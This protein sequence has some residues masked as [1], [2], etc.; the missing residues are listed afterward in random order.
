MICS[1]QKIVRARI[2]FKTTGIWDQ[3]PSMWALITSITN[4]TRKT[5]ALTCFRIASYSDGIF[6]ITPASFKNTKNKLFK[7]NLYVKIFFKI[8]YKHILTVN[9][10]KNQT[11]NDHKFYQSRPACICIDRCHHR[12]SLILPL[13]C[14]RKVYIRGIV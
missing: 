2:A 3:Y 4:Y 9:N 13:D 11:H 6:C 1:I 5:F 14:I 8:T 10:S 12:S 7:L